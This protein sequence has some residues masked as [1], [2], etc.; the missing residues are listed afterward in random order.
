MSKILI[1]NIILEYLIPVCA[2][3]LV[4][5]CAYLIANS[6]EQKGIDGIG[7]VLGIVIIMRIVIA[8]IAFIFLI[9]N[10]IRILVTYRHELTGIVPILKKIGCILLIVLPILG[11]IPLIFSVP[12]SN[13]LYDRKY[14]TG[15]GAYSVAEEEY[16]LPSQFRNELIGRGL[17]STDE[18]NLLRNEL[19][20]KFAGYIPGRFDEY[21]YADATMMAL[22]DET[23]YDTTNNAVIPDPGK[24]TRGYPAYI[25]NAVLLRRDEAD[26]LQYFPYARYDDKLYLTGNDYPFFNDFYV[27]CKILYVDGD[28]YAIIG[29]AES[30]D[31]EKSYDTFD[32]P[33]YMILAEK[34]SIT[35]FVDGKYYPYG[36]I[37]NEGWQFEM[38]PNTT[39]HLYSSYTPA[40]YPVKK[41]D[42]LDV[43]AINKAA[44]ELQ[45]GI[46]KDS[47]SAHFAKKNNVPTAE[48]PDPTSIP[49]YSEGSSDAE[50]DN[51]IISDVCEYTFYA[52]ASDG[53]A[54]EGVIINMCTDEKCIPITTDANGMAVFSGPPD[55]YHV[56][57]VR[58]P[59]KWKL[60][61]GS[62]F[63]T[64]SV[65]QTFRLIFEQAED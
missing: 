65:S 26:T 5:L 12:I 32:R 42:R 40:N 61:G 43:S 15:K 56:Q 54:I 17:Y 62:E 63:Y 7:N 49:G 16:K 58:V 4:R 64:G 18:S 44:E 34:E 6:S 46:L 9:V 55:E 21:Y 53:E 2:I 20:S 28:I 11:S 23:F 57:I 25:Y 38:H 3:A 37:G 10:P 19:N 13:F 41:V 14:G 47:A 22:E 33:Y 50:N 29:V 27:E 35:T 52:N 36:A 24:D 59:R 30:Y 51:N 48:D 39:E 8:V 1:K 31:I 45:N 60:S